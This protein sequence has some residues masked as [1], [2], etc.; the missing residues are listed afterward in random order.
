LKFSILSTQI[1]RIGKEIWIGSWAGC[2]GLC[3]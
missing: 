2:G 3:L 1:I